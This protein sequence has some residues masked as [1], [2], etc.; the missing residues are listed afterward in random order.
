[1]TDPS[2]DTRTRILRTALAEFS[3]R[4]Y[5]ATSV[6]EIAEL[7]GVTK[8]AVLYHFP[9]KADLLAAL[10]EPML[11][12]L[13]AT[14]AA[15]ELRA[16]PDEAR[17]ATLEGMLQV[18]LTHRYLLRVNL[19]DL[20]LAAPGPGFDRFKGAML[21]AGAL[22]AGPAPD[23][24][25]QVRATQ[26]IAMLADP[27]VLFADAPTAAL[28]AAVL[29]GVRR[30]LGLATPTSAA[31][32]AARRGRGRPSAVSPEMAATAHRLFEAGRTAEEVAA[33]LGVSRATVYRRLSATEQ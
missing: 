17:W 28:Q 4:G 20:A 24:A 29:D 1:M 18:W 32:P 9:A 30:L 10:T 3:A 11:D 12:D 14:L 21:K 27:V 6:R 19:H 25:G 2:P 13:E 23:F 22:V 8:A 33:E 15:A 31:P 16:D 26:A 5:H 7:V